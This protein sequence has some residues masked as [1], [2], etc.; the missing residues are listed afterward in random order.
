MKLGEY[1]AAARAARWQW[2]MHDC[3]AWPAR[4]AGVPVPPYSSEAEAEAMLADAGGI[5]ALWEK[6]GH[7]HIV[8]T[9]RPNAGDVGV[10]KVVGRELTIV[11]CGAI[12]TGKRWA[13]IPFSGGLAAA[14]AV[15]VKAWRPLCHKR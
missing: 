12:Y 2:G 15:V 7:G 11:E 13:F 9:D 10:I 3:C 8:A 1:L 4:W 6:H 5:V 14:S